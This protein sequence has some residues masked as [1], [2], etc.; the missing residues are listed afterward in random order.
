MSELIPVVAATG[1]VSAIVVVLCILRGLSV[2]RAV[3]LLLATVVAIVTR[4]KDRREACTEIVDLVTRKEEPL[5]LLR[6]RPVR[7]ITQPPD[8]SILSQPATPA[9]MQL[10]VEAAS[11]ADAMTDQ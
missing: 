10:P 5:A 7:V 6:R 4:N 9:P 1:G 2:A 3:A 11:E 8:T